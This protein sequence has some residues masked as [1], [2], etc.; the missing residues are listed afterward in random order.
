MVAERIDSG[1]CEGASD[2]IEGEIEVGQTEEGEEEG[3]ELIDEFDMKQDL[4]GQG[5]VGVP[6][7]LK[8]NEGVDGSEES[9]VQPSSS[10]RYEFRNGICTLSVMS[11]SDFLMLYLPGTSVSP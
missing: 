11:L 1:I 8:V 5:V 4:S 2:E 3:D 10:L 6:D 7:L 9:T